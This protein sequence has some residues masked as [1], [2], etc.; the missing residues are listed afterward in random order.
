MF[1]FSL[2]KFMTINSLNIMAIQQI[3]VWYI[4]T[5]IVQRCPHSG[6]EQI[7][8]G[9]QPR[10]LTLEVSRIF[11]IIYCQKFILEI[12]LGGVS[13]KKNLPRVS[14]GSQVYTGS[15]SISPEPARL[16]GHFNCTLSVRGNSICTLSTKHLAY[17]SAIFLWSLDDS[18]VGQLAT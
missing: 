1:Y 15:F 16:T 14:S 18:L 3:P 6:F 10:L 2:M 9:L 4:S 8:P 11:I 12:L 13:F 17:R 7:F 5:N